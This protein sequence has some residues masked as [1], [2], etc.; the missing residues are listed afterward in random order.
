[1]HDEDSIPLVDGAPSG[2]A[3]IHEKVSSAAATPRGKRHVPR[4]A[5]QNTHICFTHEDSAGRIDNVECP[6]INISLRGF[7]IEID[8]LLRA[9]TRGSV[10]YRAATGRPVH[11][12]CCV[13]RCQPLAP[14]RFHLSL[15]LDR[16]LQFE[17]TKPARLGIGREVAPGIRPRKLREPAAEP[18]PSGK[19]FQI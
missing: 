18:S 17:E 12:G 8:T 6:V 19:S 4:T 15:K 13:L 11:V 10:T 5:C 1:L 14:G 7:A 9:G 2:A 3:I 16:K